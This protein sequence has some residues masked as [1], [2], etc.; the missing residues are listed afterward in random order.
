M[1]K[2]G[3]RGIQMLARGPDKIKKIRCMTQF[4][5][6]HDDIV[7]RRRP[8]TYEQCQQAALLSPI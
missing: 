8:G 1:K 2:H 7:V 3:T 5:T 4:D 6:G